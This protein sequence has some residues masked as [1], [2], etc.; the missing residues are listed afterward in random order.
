MPQAI[1][2][3]YKAILDVPKPPPASL[4][5]YR[6]PVGVLR[7][8]VTRQGTAEPVRFATLFTDGYEFGGPTMSDGIYVIRDVPVGTYTLTVDKVGYRGDSRSVTV[9]AG[10]EA[11][12]EFDLVHE[13]RVSKG[14]YFQNQGT[15]HDCNLFAPFLGQTLTLPDDVGFIKFAAAMPNVGGVT[16][17]LSIHEGGPTGP[18]VGSSITVV[19]EWGG[20]MIGAEWPGDGVAV[21]PGGT[22]F[23]RVERAD[24]EGVY[25]YATDANPY[26]GGMAFTGTTPHAGW[27]LFATVRGKTAAVDSVLGTVVGT[28]EDESNNPLAGAS[29]TAEP[30]GLTATTSASGEYSLILSEGV[31][32][33]TASL[34]GFESATHTNV[35]VLEGQTSVWSFTLVRDAPPPPPPASGLITN[36]DFSAGLDAWSTW[37]ERGALS[38]TIDGSGGLHLAAVGH[39]GGVYQQFLTGGSGTEITIDGFWASDPTVSN[40]QWAEVLVIDS[41]RLP[42]NGRDL[43]AGESDVVLIHK[44]DTWAHPSGWSGGMSPETFIA[45]FI[46]SGDVA[47]VVLKSGNLLGVDSG[48]RFDDIVVRAS[49]PPPP[50]DNRPPTAELAAT[51]TSGAAPLFV[52]FDGSGSSDA[53]GDALTFAWDFGDGAIASGSIS[54]HTYASEGTFIASLTVNDGRGGVATATT[55]IG[56]TPSAPV[57]DLISNGDFARGLEAWSVWVERGALNPVVQAGR[58]ELVAVGHNGGVYQQFAT[59]G[60]GSTIT[61][62]G[63]WGSDPAVANA[64]W[65]EVL[66]I[67]GTRTPTSGQDLNAGQPDVVLIHKNDTWISPGGWS[68]PMPQ[69][70]FTAS[71]DVAKIVLKS[72]NLLSVARER[73]M[74][75]SSFAAQAELPP[76]TGR[77]RHARRGIRPRETAPLTVSFDASASSDPDGD[78]LSFAWELGDGAT[79]S[80]PLASHTYTVAGSFTASVTV[81]DGR[82]GEDTANVS[83]TVSGASPP[84]GGVS[85]D[86]RLSTLGLEVIEADVPPGT[87]YWKLTTAVFESDGEIL[88]PPDGGSESHGTHSIYV[89]ALNPDG[90]PIENQEA[91]VSWPRD[92]PTQQASIRTKAA[93]DDFWGD[94]PMAGGWC[95]FFP[96]G[97]RGPYGARVAPVTDVASDEVWG[98]GMPCNRHVSYRLTW[99]W[100]QKDSGQSKLSIHGGFGGPLSMQFV[101]RAKPRIV[102]I[103]DSFSA[104]P[105][106]RRLSPETEIIGRAFLPTQP[107]DGDPLQRAREW[108]DSQRALILQYPDIDYWEAYNEPIIQTPEL[109]AWYAAFE[110]ERVRLLAEHGLRACIGNFSVG[111]TD[112]PLW[113]HFYPAFDAAKA[114]G[115]ILGLHE[116]GTPMQQ[117]FDESVG[118]G[119]FT[120]R[121]RK[122]YRQYLIPADKDIPLAITETGVDVVV[123]VG[124]KHHFTEEEYLDQ[125]MWYDSILLEDDY[126]LGATIFALEIPGWW[127]FDIAPIVD[128]L[129]D[130]VAVDP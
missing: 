91:L 55:T 14:I 115:G 81:S 98:M 125:L 110:S 33:I 92:D 121:Y 20:E 36:G 126:V 114:H 127:S 79:A 86:P 75:T 11:I 9:E 102:K 96:D 88:P 118:E 104:A 7:G 56:V 85:W 53:D 94:F 50:P 103:L 89:K 57:S 112:L 5:P 67:D 12:V 68:A 25:L 73:S 119:W 122:L 61:I 65:A 117:H 17:K 52:S 38:P 70:S 129:A 28:V 1:C 76:A 8:R 72:G 40:A 80:G 6:G 30:G 48:T 15:C 59:G 83:V 105:E 26:A 3:Q 74:T 120:G 44:M 46:A 18:Q 100:S 60:A 128:Q 84:P 69:G 54:T 99:K 62:D 13:G 16:M 95:P 130:Y 90:S 64:Q 82:G 77:P 29:V 107:M 63:F 58:L 87:W 101:D 32:S 45:K 10:T 116:Y 111:N 19:P 24:G 2:P 49:S 37:T 22:Y 113:P 27:D 108:W 109:M 123:S 43:N 31:Y 124:W 78:T 42:V 4:E 47:T 93:I 21:T 97:P 39:N 34:V 23:L 71:G 41:D 51:P 66:V 35:S 106:I